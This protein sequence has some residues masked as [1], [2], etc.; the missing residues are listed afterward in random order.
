[1]RNCAIAKTDAQKKTSLRAHTGRQFLTE[2]D[3]PERTAY[4]DN[5]P[6]LKEQTLHRCSIIWSP[7]THA[8]PH[9]QLVPWSKHRPQN[10]LQKNGIVS[11]RGGRPLVV[12]SW[13]STI[14]KTHT[15]KT[16][17]LSIRADEDGSP[18]TEAHLKGHHTETTNQNLNTRTCHHDHKYKNPPPYRSTCPTTWIAQISSKRH[19]KKMGV[20]FP[21]GDRPLVAKR[22]RRKRKQK[23]SKST[24][25]QTRHRCILGP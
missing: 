24:L 9:V 21:G 5:K 16:T 8:E 13:N 12:N 11:P 14:T 18:H 7:A 10:T 19:C 2:D 6:R 23:R 17:S 1:M 3:T 22:K 4:E 20:V 25:S 15:K